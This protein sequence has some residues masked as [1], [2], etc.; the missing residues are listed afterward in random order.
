VNDAFDCS[1]SALHI[2]NTKPNA[3]AIAEIEFRKIA[4]QVPFA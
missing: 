2:V 4:V 1:L 3:I